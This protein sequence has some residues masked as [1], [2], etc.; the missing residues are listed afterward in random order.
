MA[1][2]DTIQRLRDE[3]TVTAAMTERNA[4]RIKEHAE[5]LAAN[6][7]ATAAHREWLQQHEAAM[8]SLTTKLDRI[9][10]LILK[11]HGGNGAQ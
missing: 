9:A 4:A 1:L 3:L 11:G 6:E 5:W 7:R 2:E 10:D 8:Q